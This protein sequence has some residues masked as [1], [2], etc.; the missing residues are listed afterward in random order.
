VPAAQRFTATL[1]QARGEGGRW[2]KVPFD[3]REVFGQA[4]PPVHGTVNGTPIRARL[5][6]YG[7]ETYLGLRREIR[8]AA[9]IEVGDDV[10]VV[11]EL[12]DAPRAVELPAEL[13]AALAADPAVRVAYEDL[14]FTHRREYAQWVGEAKR[15]ETRDKRVARALDMLREGIKHP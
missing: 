3:A 4:R 7:G 2:L 15:Q 13:A 14:S 10:E 8:D 9:G 11:L 5:S 1:Q 12:D 6:V